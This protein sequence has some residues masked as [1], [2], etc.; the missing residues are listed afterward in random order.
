ME[1]GGGGEGWHCIAISIWKSLELKAVQIESTKNGKVVA[2]FDGYCNKY[3]LRS[4]AFLFIQLDRGYKK[5][6]FD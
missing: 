5:G 1:V 3:I 2:I 4:F 6:A